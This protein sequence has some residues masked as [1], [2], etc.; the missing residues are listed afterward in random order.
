IGL[1]AATA[2]ALLGLDPFVAGGPTVVPPSNRFVVVKTCEIDQAPG[3]H[4]FS[5]TTS[6]ETDVSTAQ[7][8][9][10]VDTKQ[11]REG[12]LGFLGIGPGA[13]KTTKTTTSNSQTN[14]TVTNDTQVGTVS[15]FSTATEPPYAVEIYQDAVFGSFAFR[16]APP[17]TTT[18]RVTG[19]TLD[20]AGKPRA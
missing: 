18:A 4:D 15:L 13:N 20:A 8:T 5:L 7:V 19:T 12:W 14:D 3:R 2:S 10:K 16:L 11:E 17:L 6:S 1:D 9:T